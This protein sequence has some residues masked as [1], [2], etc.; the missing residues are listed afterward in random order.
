MSEA[1]LQDVLYTVKLLMSVVYCKVPSFSV[2]SSIR[3]WREAFSRSISPLRF[4]T[5]TI[6]QLPA[7]E[8]RSLVFTCLGRSDESR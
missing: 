3:P 1:S 6:S 8:H 2:M 5:R 7:P 4:I